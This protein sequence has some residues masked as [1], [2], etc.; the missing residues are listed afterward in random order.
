MRPELEKELRQ[1]RPSLRLISPVSFYFI[2]LMGVFNIVVGLAMIAI[3]LSFDDPVLTVLTAIIPAWVWGALFLSLGVFKLVALKANHWLLTRSSLLAGVA[4][5]SSW[6][7]ALVIQVL[8]VSDNIFLTTCW[9][10]IAIT[11]VIVYVHFL[12]PQEMRLLNGKV[13]KGNE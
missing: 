6:A 10:T 9:I 3:G 13:F 8:Q 5:K 1:A 7:V 2:A 4:L 12:P 11:Q